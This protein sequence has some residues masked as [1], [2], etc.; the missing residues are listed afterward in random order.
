MRKA[1]DQISLAELGISDT[2]VRKSAN[3]SLL[4]EIAGPNNAAKADILAERLRD[5][6]RDEAFISRPMIRGE[7]RLVGLDHSISIQEIQDIIREKG[8]CPDSEIKMGPIRPMRN[9][10]GM[11]WVQCPLTAANRICALGRVK[12]GW[13]SVRV[14][15][16]GVRPRQCFK[17]WEF[18]HVRGMCKSQADWSNHCFKCGALSHGA[19]ACS[20][21]PNCVVCREKGRDPSHRVGSWG[22][23]ASGL[24]QHSRGLPGT[25]RFVESRN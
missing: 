14:E 17:C 18:G 25:G 6:M 8:G 21:P 15:S 5:V 10:L 24:P 12:I 11:I 9:G 19:R 13:S 1:R 22:C 23:A 16:L 2:R 3:G 7:L 4:V 20:N